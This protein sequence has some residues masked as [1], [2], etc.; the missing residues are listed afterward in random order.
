MASE[1]AWKQRLQ[2]IPRIM[3]GGE[4]WFERIIGS[5]SKPRHLSAS[6]G[7]A[8]STQERRSIPKA[9]QPLYM[10]GWKS[11]GFGLLMLLLA[12]GIWYLFLISG[13]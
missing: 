8:W 6:D 10:R 2:W 5:F 13:L 7:D 12:I 9:L 3:A 1:E 4:R 11:L